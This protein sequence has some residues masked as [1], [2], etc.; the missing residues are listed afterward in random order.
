VPALG[1]SGYDGATV[2]NLL[3]MRSGIRF[4][5]DYLNPGAEVRLIE[6]A[7]GWAPGSMPVYRGRC[8]TSWSA[9]A[10]ASP[11]GPFEYRSCETDV[12]G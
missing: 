8:M 9:A 4:S 5:E 10:A 2:R 1:E 7:I 11:R 12:L 6:Q 3:D